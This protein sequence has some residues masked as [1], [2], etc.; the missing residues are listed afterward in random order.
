M[1]TSGPKWGPDHRVILERP[2]KERPCLLYSLL[3]PEEEES[4]LLVEEI[5]DPHLTPPLQPYRRT[6]HVLQTTCVLHVKEVADS[7]GI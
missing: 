1:I 6:N 7:Q 3:P 5:K 4:K 2:V